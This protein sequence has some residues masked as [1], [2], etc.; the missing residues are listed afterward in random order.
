MRQ[1]DSY[2]Y[3]CGAADC[4]CEMVRAGVKNIALSHPCDSKE[5]ND[6]FIEYMEVLKKEYGVGYYMEEKPLITDLFPVS[7]NLN[8]YNIIFYYN[9]KYLQEYLQIKKDKETY[10]K[11]GIYDEKRT[12]LAIRY[13]KLLSYSDEGIERLLKNNTEKE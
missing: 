8:R 2:S 12:E 6:S 11:E 7:L 5:E 4:F 13:G 1:I 3:K 9:E 10:L